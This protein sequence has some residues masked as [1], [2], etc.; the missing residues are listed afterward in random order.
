MHGRGGGNSIKIGI[1][2]VISGVFLWLVFRQIDI[3]LVIHEIRQI[4][5]W[6]LI[7]A[8]LVYFAGVWVRTTRWCIL[9]RPIAQRRTINLFPIYIISY[10]ANN[11]LP[12]RIGD[13]YRAYIV[14]KNQKVSKSATLV[15]IGVERIFDGLTML[16][17]LLISIMLFPIENEFVKQAAT[18]GSIV[19]LGAIGF[20]YILI[21]KKSWAE[22]IFDV[23]I[24]R[25]RFGNNPRVKDIFDN[26]LRGLDSLKDAKEILRVS[27]LSLGTWLIEALSY[28]LVLNAF[29]FFGSF[30]VAVATMA[31]VNL[32]IIVPSA[33]GY[34]GPFELGCFIIL[35]TAGYGNLTG[36]S[37][38]VA[39]AYALIVHVVVQ[40]IPST[41]LGLLF[42][43]REHIS[44]EEIEAE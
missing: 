22:W 42:M 25:T 19:F 15:T 6:W 33:P 37:E 32:M 29:G 24:R 17:L 38:N 27:I 10:M 9:M 43:W 40:W 11:I 31:M 18:L 21:L 36:F 7:P 8:I 35:G 12:M 1:G 23:I 30:I 39:T 4:K 28:Y 3:R 13:I 34:F 5:A 20:C 14:G 26:L 44:F 16:T 41:F 2:I